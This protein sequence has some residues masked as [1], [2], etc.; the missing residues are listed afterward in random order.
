MKKFNFIIG[1]KQIIL[2]CLTLILGAAI[3]VNYV[4]SDSNT[5]SETE[6]VENSSKTYG[7][8]AFV[9]ETTDESEDEDVDYFEQARLDRLESR[10]TAIQTLQ[11]ILNGGDSTEEEQ[12]VAA[13]SA[14]AVSNYI[15]KESTIES[16]LLAAGFEDAVVYLD[17]DGANIVVKSG[18]LDADSIAQIKDI[19][20]SE[21]EVES[22]N[23]R[24]F[25][26]K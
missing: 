4:V 15:E 26:V 23:I 7:T 13:K 2:T 11:S 12:A 10:D 25:D 9:S 22:E 21:V 14:E 24:I 17:E 1:K 16:L 8:A 20:L 18:D 19:L 5:I 6:V 3:Y